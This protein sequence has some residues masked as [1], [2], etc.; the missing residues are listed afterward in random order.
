M[1]IACLLVRRG[2]SA[3]EAL[4][5]V[6]E[7]FRSMPKSTL[8]KHATRTSPETPAQCAAVRRF[9]DAEVRRR[10]LAI[11]GARMR[12]LLGHPPVEETRQLAD[13]R[14]RV[15]GCLLGGAV[16]DA[17]G[18]PVEFAS[19]AEIRA[20]F[21]RDGITELVIDPALGAAAITDDT[22]MTLFTAEGLLRGICRAHHKGIG[23][24][25]SCLGTS[26]LRW[27]VTQDGVPIDPG[28]SRAGESPRAAKAR[29]VRWTLGWAAERGCFA[30]A[31]DVAEGLGGIDHP[32]WLVR[33]PGLHA[34]RAP[35]TTCVTA[36]R[37]P[38]FVNTERA[39]N[40]SKGCGGVM[41]V[42]PCGLVASA[43]VESVWNVA[44]HAARLT[45]GHPTGWLAA[46]AFA[47]MIR[48]LLDGETIG[49]AL[50]VAR[51]FLGGATEG[52]HLVHETVDALD[53]AEAL[54]A[55]S[56]LPSAE[57]IGTLGGGWIAEEALAIGV[58]C[59][60]VG[61]RTGDVAAALRLAVNHSGDSDSTGSI[62]GQL[63]GTRFGVDAIPARWRQ[64][65]ELREVIEQVADDIVTEFRDDARWRERY[66]GY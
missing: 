51:T 27:L 48:V 4:A 61:E 31:P 20:R 54:V 58:A 35:G 59:A 63:L 10:A 41:R 18:W 53:A 33:V 14:R 3:D 52:T 19:L 22:Q 8:P 65:V 24:P 9:A 42:A 34:Q 47:V 39:R 30:D 5:V 38:S 36:L 25:E 23:G 11:E 62:A 17:L 37:D 6:A 21:G 50:R 13:R 66:P 12:A 46:G 57:A 29:H 1:V 15:R 64:A 43:S 55:R 28:P 49:D 44:C 26:Y 45:H 60:L 7:G 32:G 2:M 56:P 40:D 16:G